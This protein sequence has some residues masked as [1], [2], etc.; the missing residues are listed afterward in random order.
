MHHTM[1]PR[2]YLLVFT[3]LIALTALTV[4]LSFLE[5]G[6]WHTVIGLL[7]GAVKAVLIGLFFMHLL[8][9]PRLTWLIA[10]SGVYWLGILLGLTMTDYV[11]RGWMKWSQ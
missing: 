8:H 5:L 2:T 10:L 6:G 11:S 9:A 3:A 7:I 1:T 4:G